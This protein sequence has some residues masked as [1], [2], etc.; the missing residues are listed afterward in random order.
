[1]PRS[2]SNCTECGA[3]V[4]VSYS[5]SKPVPEL[6]KCKTHTIGAL[7]QDMIDWIRYCVVSTIPMIIDSEN[8]I[9]TGDDMIGYIKKQAY[10]RNKGV[11]NA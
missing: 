8:T 3:V 5:K 11:K 7:E 2:T 6:D 10:A 9:E 4:D 1:M